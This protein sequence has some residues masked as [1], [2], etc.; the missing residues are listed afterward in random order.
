MF[1]YALEKGV[2]VLKKTNINGTEASWVTMEEFQ[3]KMLDGTTGVGGLKSILRPLIQSDKNLFPLWS[4]FM[5]ARR[6]H[7]FAKENKKVRTTE[8]ERR[9]IF[10]EVGYDP[11]TQTFINPQ[12]PEM[13]LVSS[14]YQAWNDAFV[15]FMV[16]T[17]IVT[18]EMG[19][20]F[21]S[22]ADY[23]PFYR[24]WSEESDVNDD[25]EISK[26]IDDTLP[27][28]MNRPPTMFA[29]ISGVK[30]PRKA[31]GGE[32][33]VDDP[34]ENIIQ[35]AFAGLQA[36][37]A[38]VAAQ[39]VYRNGKESREIITTTNPVEATHTIRVDGKDVMFIANDPLLNEMLSGIM[40][41]KMPYLN[42][43]S[44]PSRLLRDLVTRSPDFLAANLLR[45][46]GS[47]WLTS[48]ADISPFVGAMKNMISGSDDVA[49]QALERAGLAGGF[50]NMNTPADFR[51]HMIKSWRLQGD[52]KDKGAAWN[53]FNTIW[54]KSGQWST[55]SDMAVRMEVWEDTIKRMEADG[56]YDRS[57]IEAEADFQ[58]SEVLNF[59]RQGGSPAYRIITA[60]VPFT[61][62]RIQGIDVL[63][64]AATG[65]YSS[66]IDDVHTGAAMSRFRNRAF[67]MMALAGMYWLLMHDDDDYTGQTAETREQNLIIPGSA[68]TGGIPIKIPKPFEV[69]FFFITVPEAL[70][71][72][73][74][75]G[76]DDGRQTANAMKRGLIA[77]LHMNPTPQVVKPMLESVTNHSFWTGRNIVP[78]HLE[79]MEPYMQYG[80]HTGTF[81]K[82]LGR[83]VNYSPSKIEH[84]LRGYTGT[85]GGYGLFVL[86]A[87][88]R[89]VADIP[90]APV[91]R[92]HDYPMLR[93]F[94]AAPG[95]GA[96]GALQNFYD[97]REVSDGTMNAIRKLRREGFSEDAKELAEDRK[98]IVKTRS[99]VLA[100]DRQIKG[101]RTQIRNVRRSKATDAE[102]IRRTDK[103][104]AQIRKA[105]R[106]LN[107]L[108]KR[109][110]LPL[111]LSLI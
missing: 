21:S 107:A 3:I 19:D 34:L 39:K 32:R 90:D 73:L 25:N 38:N 45:D 77:T 15:Q 93:R 46:S 26:A 100:L 76:Q 10:R 37:M 4:A 54:Q 52:I 94:T 97:L 13:E 8:S 96:R 51:K 85:L 103:I 6:E 69:G 35:N 43:F 61:G 23:L 50:E 57:I 20:I 110:D 86:D 64:R 40:D 56:I 67:T 7:R 28:G 14:N 102:K 58:A 30:P 87:A 62:A 65:K 74:V 31:K 36:G 75:S 88:T 59:N 2:P 91:L 83:L 105:T 55:R 47:A 60:L 44:G 99:R 92:F 106:D 24:Q 22:Y 111:D 68:L 84:I 42:F 5:I 79:E 89:T 16:D 71:S 12:Y 82:Q 33:K 29:G 49:F 109:S 98:G 72:F 48:G 104:E 63:Y 108:R 27:A 101:L 81:S 70:L 17:G 1:V 18:Q 66:N 9:E 95:G 41:A 53:L 78:T 11:E 80:D